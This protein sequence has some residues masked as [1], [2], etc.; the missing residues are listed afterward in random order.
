VAAPVESADLTDVERLGL[1]A[2]QLRESADYREAKRA[3]PRAGEQWDM[4]GCT[5]IVPTPHIAGS[6]AR[7]ARAAGPTSS[8]LEG[9]VAVGIVVVQGP[10]ADLQFTDAEL[11]KVVAE[12]Q[13]GLGYYATTNPLA[14]ISFSYDIQNVTLA[15]PANPVAPDLEALWRDPAMG[16]LGFS[17]VER[18]QHLRGEPAQ[19]VRHPVD[20]LRVLHQVPAGLVRVREH[21]RAAAR[22]GLPQRRLGPGEH[23]PGVRP[24]DRPHLQLSGRVRRQQL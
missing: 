1:R 19:R 15:T 16:A 18:R 24:R 7:D 8:Y 14:G 2:L 20:V 4:P 22:H 21:R 23:R 13:N 11:T 5:T 17:A 10:T 9:T 12:V 3:R 6:L